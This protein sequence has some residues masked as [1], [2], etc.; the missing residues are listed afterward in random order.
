MHTIQHGA[1]FV[2]KNHQPPQ[3]QDAMR[4]AK[5]VELPAQTAPTSS[6]APKARQR[7]TTQ[8][9]SHGYWQP[10][11]LPSDAPAVGLPCPCETQHTHNVTH[12]AK[13]GANHE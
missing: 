11:C 10:A 9:S 2:S 1:Y 5:A 13:R 6:S 7:A 12:A 4:L 8:A 3:Q